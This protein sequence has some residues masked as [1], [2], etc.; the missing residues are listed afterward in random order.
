MP[1]PSR[2]N[3]AWPLEGL[4]VV[5]VVLGFYLLQSQILDVRY[6]IHDGKRGLAHAQERASGELTDTQRFVELAV[7]DLEGSQLDISQ[8]KVDLA[9][10]LE[11]VQRGR[12]HLTRLIESR[13][14]ELETTLTERLARETASFDIVRAVAEANASRL[15]TISA[16]SERTSEE[17]KRRMILPTL[18]LRGN[19]TVGSGV[20]VYSQRQ[21]AVSDG[22]IYT[23]FFVTAYHVVA[24]VLADR[25]DQ[26]LREVHVMIEGDAHRTEVY[27][28]RL[29]VFDRSRDIAL[30]R[31]DTTHEFRQL[32]DLMTREE[33]EQVDIFSPAYA[34]G[35][36]LGNRPL[37][38]L[39]EVSS[40]SKVVAEKTF[41]MLNAPTFFGN[42][43]GGIYLVPSCKLIG[44][45]SMIYTYG[46][47]NPT[48]VPHMGLFVPLSAVYDWLD[49]EGYGFVYRRSSVP[50][51]LRWKLVYEGRERVA[52]RPA[53][54]HER[55]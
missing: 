27:S 46:K 47:S 10:S 55:G 30:L 9:A 18:Q 11:A 40:Q 49:D 21:P 35:C 20:L 44:V 19:G 41:W 3:R 6:A 45:S 38:T 28:A 48:V 17:R 2:R 13:A 7:E 52:P 39:G 36:P 26:P 8:T 32:A 50:R 24:E 1:Y 15:R 25:L 5:L 31:L 51:H 12:E 23:T 34:V 33:L 42:S 4:K 14:R 22:D 16:S 37:P 54:A 43:G 53:S 29:V